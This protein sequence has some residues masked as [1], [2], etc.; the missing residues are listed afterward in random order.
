M[1]FA[2]SRR[3]TNQPAA[4]ATTATAAVIDVDDVDDAIGV[5]E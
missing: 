2:V 4:A 3:G 1:K 5:D